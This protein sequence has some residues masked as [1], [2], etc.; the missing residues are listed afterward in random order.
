MSR[1]V[2][3]PG[4]SSVMTMAEPTLR[5]V[6]WRAASA[7]LS[8]GATWSKA[9]LTSGPIGML[10][11]A[12]CPPEPTGSP[13]ASQPRK[14][15]NQV[16]DHRPRVAEKH[17]RL[18]LVVELVLNP[19]EPRRHASFDH[20]HR[21]GL[22]D[23]EDRHPI[24]GAALVMSRRGVGDVVGAD[25]DGHVGARNVGGYLIHLDQLVVG[26]V[27][28]GQ[29]D[30]HVSRH[31]PGDG[32]DGELDLCAAPGKEV[33][34]L[35]DLVLRLG[36]GH[37]VTRD[38][39]DQPGGLEYHGRLLRGSASYRALLNLRYS[40]G[41]DLPKGPEH[42]VA[43]VPIHRPR[44]DERQQEARRS[45]QGSR[46]D[47]DLVVQDEPH[48]RAAQSRVRVQQGDDSWHVGAA[49]GNDQENAEDQRQR[50][51]DQEQPA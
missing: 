23:L 44:H 48:G 26:Y 18:V 20:H 38:D 19:S 9:R 11:W 34:E 35:A 17:H 33:G 30:I 13:C 27:G 25:H 8:C 41:L 42:D 22:V 16:A 3:M 36:H 2:M 50:H 7:M 29:Q 32:V 47:E 1:S 4:P 5:A 24:D 49:D 39:D 10:S 45:I 14:L 28:L 21:T 6:I 46:D 31:A 40:P 37:A 51:Y 12:L 15:V 43:E